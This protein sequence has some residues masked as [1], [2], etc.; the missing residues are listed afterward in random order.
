MDYRLQRRAT[1]PRIPSPSPH[2]SLFPS[3]NN[4]HAPTSLA[5]STSRT[6]PLNR[7][8]TAPEKSPL[9][10]IFSRNEQQIAKGRELLQKK[11]AKAI[12]ATSPPKPQQSAITPNSAALSFESEAESVTIVVAQAS[13][14]HRQTL[15]LDDREPEWEICQKQQP[16]PVPNPQLETSSV[17]SLIRTPSQQR[18]LEITKASALRSH[19]SS[20]PL[21]V[22]SPL[23]RMAS[24]RSPPSSA[25][26]M[27]E[28]RGEDGNGHSGAGNA[29]LGVGVARSVSVSRAHSPRTLV[30]TGTD[31]SSSSERF[32][33]RATLTPTMVEVRNRKSQRV[34]LEDA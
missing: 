29:M 19:P 18:N 24:L 4:S 5:T 17:S 22:A 32:V 28:K 31:L 2:L 33:E 25:R 26:R 8:K 16:L 6:K 12:A 21:D 30:R 10:Q 14:G 11:P 7:S 34:T 1:S 13:P 27:N 15:R 20:A 9:R 3:T 23:Q